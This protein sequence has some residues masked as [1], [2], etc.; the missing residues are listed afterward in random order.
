LHN[1]IKESNKSYQLYSKEN[2]RLINIEEVN[3][4]LFNNDLQYIIEIRK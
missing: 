3:S 2:D 4:L 1:E